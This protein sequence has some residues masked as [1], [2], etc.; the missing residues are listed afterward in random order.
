MVKREKLNGD[1]Y[2]IWRR[3]IQFALNDQ[4][5]LDYIDHLMTEPKRVLCFSLQGSMC[6]CFGFGCFLALNSSEEREEEEEEEGNEA[7]EEEG[8]REGQIEDEEAGKEKDGEKAAQDSGKGDDVE[9]DIEAEAQEGE[10]EDSS[11]TKSDALAPTTGHKYGLGQR[12]GKKFS[13]TQDKPLV[14]TPSPPASP[15]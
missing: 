5:L 2:D 13:N 10:E 4:G 9:K 12:E 15:H 11:T 8:E 1:N 14:L 3:K 6:V 7:N